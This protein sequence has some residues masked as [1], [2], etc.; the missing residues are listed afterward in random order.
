VRAEYEGPA[1]QEKQTGKA[2]RKSTEGRK[3]E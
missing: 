3:V 2:D 1:E